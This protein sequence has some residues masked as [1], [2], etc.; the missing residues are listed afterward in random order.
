M[1]GEEENR[2]PVLYTLCPEGLITHHSTV[3]LLSSINTRILREHLTTHHQRVIAGAE[4]FSEAGIVA[5]RVNP[6]CAG[7]DERFNHALSLGVSN[8][9]PFPD[10]RKR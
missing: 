4:R 1:K 10:G 6:G 8:N 2:K 5:S 3:S 7:E 9:H